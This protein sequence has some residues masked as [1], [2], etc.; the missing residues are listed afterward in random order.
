MRAEREIICDFAGQIAETWFFRKRPRFGMDSD[1]QSA[2]D[3]AC[4][5]C[6]SKQTAEAYMK[7]C[8]LASQDLVRANFKAVQAVAVALSERKTSAIKT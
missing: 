4:R 6:G 3:M 5:L 7:Y 8:F 1:N 2:V